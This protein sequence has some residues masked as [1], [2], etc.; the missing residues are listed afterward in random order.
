MAS[1]EQSILADIPEAWQGLEKVLTGV[2]SERM[3]QPGA[4]GRWSAK[5]PYRARDDLGKG[6]AE[7][8]SA[9]PE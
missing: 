4:V 3:D 8:R 1:L 7:D 2:P 5:G 9:L 6:G